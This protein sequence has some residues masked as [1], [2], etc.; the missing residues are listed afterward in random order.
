GVLVVLLRRRSGGRRHRL[1]DIA[2]QL[3]ARLVEADDR[4]GRVVRLGVQLQHVLHPVDELAVYALGQ[5]PRRL[6]PRLEVAFFKTRRMVSSDTDS[7][8]CISTR[9]SASIRAVQVAR[10]WGAGP[11]AVAM[12]SASA[13]PSRIGSAAGRGRSCRAAPSPPVANRRRTLATVPIDTPTSS[14]IS[15]SVSPASARRRICTRYRC[16]P[17]SGPASRSS[18]AARS[19]SVNATTYRFAMPHLLAGEDSETASKI[20]C[21]DPL[22]TSVRSAMRPA[23]SALARRAPPPGRRGLVGG[24]TMT[25]QTSPG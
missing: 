14:A 19:S 5:A 4:A 2:P 10:P 11:H 13:L 22:E 23:G 24:P 8:T 1:D 20:H 17:V 3:L 16:P 7:T 15:S 12:T 18:R 6:P 21:G 25:V 9:R